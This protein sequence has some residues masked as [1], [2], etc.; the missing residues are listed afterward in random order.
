MFNHA[1]GDFESIGFAVSVVVGVTFLNAAA[2][3]TDEELSQIA[4][5]T[6]IAGDEGIERFD[7]VDKPQFREK[8]ERPV[9]GRWLGA[10]AFGLEP[11]EQVIG[12]D[13]SAIFDD[14]F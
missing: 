6:M 1:A 10:T 11:I 3:L 4:L 5:M 14:E 13:R 9:N 7:S 8:V 12:F 2:T